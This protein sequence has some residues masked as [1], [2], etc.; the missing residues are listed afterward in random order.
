ME[1]VVVLCPHNFLG[2]TQ[3]PPN[4]TTSNKRPLG[5]T[6]GSVLRQREKAELWASMLVSKG[7][8]GQ[9]RVTE[10]RIGYSE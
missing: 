7:R 5:E 2:R 9:E 8:N 3:T 1:R 6:P 10:F 4:L